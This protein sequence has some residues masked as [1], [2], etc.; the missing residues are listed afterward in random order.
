L[1]QSPILK[2][3]SSMRKNGVN[4][5]VMGGQACVYYGAAE[6]SRDLDLLILLSPDNLDHLC[7][8]LDDLDAVLGM[9]DLVLAKKTQRN[10][11]WP[12]IQLLVE[13]S[14]F[15]RPKEPAAQSVD[16]WLR[17]LRNAQGRKPSGVGHR[18]VG[19]AHAAERRCA[20]RRS[21]GQATKN[22]GL[23]DW[24]SCAF[25]GGGSR[26]PRG[27][28][29]RPALHDCRDRVRRAAIDGDHDRHLTGAGKGARN[30]QIDLVEARVLGLRGMD[31]WD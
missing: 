25:A 24:L 27:Q 14:Y 29:R 12:M 4:C 23:P 16:F 7:A 15:P 10:K 11:D 31:G 3:L 8:A 17:E 9:Q 13:Q 1:T 5:L 30:F 26:R 2:A 20:L 22:D 28:A 6:F 18:F 19:P 21:V